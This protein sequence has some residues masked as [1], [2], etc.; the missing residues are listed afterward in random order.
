MLTT[1][2]VF[3][4]DMIDRDA[5][6]HVKELNEKFFGL[7]YYPNTTPGVG[8]G[9]GMPLWLCSECH[10][11]HKGAPSEPFDWVGLSAAQ[12]EKYLAIWRN[13]KD[14][15]NLKQVQEGGPRWLISREGVVK[16]L[17]TARGLGN[18]VDTIVSLVED[19]SPKAASKFKPNW[20]RMMFIKA[21]K[22]VA[23]MQGPM[24]E[25][26]M[27]PFQQRGGVIDMLNV[28]INNLPQFDEI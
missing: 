10:P 11:D 6:K 28:P 18:H 13:V 16:K 4:P 22:I 17:R 3:P 21:C 7:K 20:N 26:V 8:D 15:N 23:I 25:H 2:R 1:K 27:E 24:K 14:I 5:K 12:T 19:D 9:S